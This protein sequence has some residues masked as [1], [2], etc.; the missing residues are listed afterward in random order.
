M[1]LYPGSILTNEYAIF[2]DNICLELV[3]QTVTPLQA[4]S[5]SESCCSDSQMLTFNCCQYQSDALACWGKCSEVWL[6]QHQHSEATCI[7]LR[8]HDSMFPS[9][10]SEIYSEETGVFLTNWLIF[11]MWCCWER[12]AWILTNNSFLTTSGTS[13]RPLGVIAR[14]FIFGMIKANVWL[15]H[16]MNESY[17]LLL[18]DILKALLFNHLERAKGKAQIDIQFLK[19]PKNIEFLKYQI[20]FSS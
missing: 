9:K 6:H 5:S 15:S 3:E 1:S 4:H 8:T 12:K 13:C 19:I 7:T 17:Q 11:Y 2:V 10:I 18:S 16:Y 14:T 20:I